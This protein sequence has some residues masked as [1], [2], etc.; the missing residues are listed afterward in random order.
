MSKRD[1]GLILLAALCVVV[2]GVL[3]WAD[4]DA[5]AIAGAI[6]AAIGRLSGANAGD[7]PSTTEQGE[8]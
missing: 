1:L 5:A 3:I 8:G 2:A 6:G 4:K 7:N